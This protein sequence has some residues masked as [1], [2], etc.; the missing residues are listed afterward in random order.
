MSGR[1]WGVGGIGME[2][3]CN[4][5]DA[6]TDCYV[7][8][9]ELGATPEEYEAAIGASGKTKLDMIVVIHG[10]RVYAA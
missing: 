7:S 2:R 3:N 5:Y 10:R 1:A 4:L 8:A 6:D 9:E